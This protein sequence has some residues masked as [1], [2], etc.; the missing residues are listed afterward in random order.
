MKITII[1]KGS[2]HKPAGWCSDMVDAPPL[3]KK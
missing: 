1:N 3:D 2:N